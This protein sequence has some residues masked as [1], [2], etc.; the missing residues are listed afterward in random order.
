M[1]ITILVMINPSPPDRRL[2]SQAHFSSKIRPGTNAELHDR[3][4]YRYFWSV[5]ERAQV[6]GLAIPEPAA[7]RF[8]AA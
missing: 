4:T 8:F 2:A 1:L 6:T 5:L 7:T 3:A